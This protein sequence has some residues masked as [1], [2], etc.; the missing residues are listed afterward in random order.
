MTLGLWWSFVSLSTLRNSTSCPSVNPATC[1]DPGG[2]FSAVLAPPV[3]AGSHMVFRLVM[4][5]GSISSDTAGDVGS[6]VPGLAAPDS[7]KESSGA[8]PDVSMLI[9]P[10]VRSISGDGDVAV[11]SVY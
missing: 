10:S 1:T 4:V 7:C 6:A 8:S 5:A 3:F 9:S 11:L 2:A